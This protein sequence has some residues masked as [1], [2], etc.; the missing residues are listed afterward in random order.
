MIFLTFFE[1][2]CFLFIILTEV[3]GNQGF[4]II[5]AGRVKASTPHVKL[6][7][8][9]VRIQCPTPDLDEDSPVVRQFLTV[10]LMS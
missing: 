3:Y 2:V 6:I 10:Q 1:V 9:A 7:D 5:L 4:Y 8:S